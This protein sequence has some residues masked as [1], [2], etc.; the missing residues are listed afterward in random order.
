MQLKKKGYVEVSVAK[1][2]ENGDITAN[3]IE[4]LRRRDTYLI[5]ISH[6][7]NVNGKKSAA[8]RNRRVRKTKTIFCFW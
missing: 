2:D 3:E 4:R 6:A 7:S 8:G 5:C 1:P